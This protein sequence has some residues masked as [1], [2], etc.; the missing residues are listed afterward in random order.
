MITTPEG[1]WPPIYDAEDL[2]RQIRALVQAT[3]FVARFW[4]L[5]SL[6]SVCQGDIV[7]LPSSV[8][9]LDEEGSPVATDDCQHWLVIGN[10]CDFARS[11]ADVAFTQLVPLVNV[12]ALTL[13][14]ID[15][16][17]RYRTSRRFYIPPWPGLE[18]GTHHFADFTRPVP[19]AKQAIGS[20]AR[21]VARMRFP[22]WVLLHSCLIRFLAR[23]D[24]RFDP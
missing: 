3:D 20:A 22:A 24:G 16:Y 9:L 23:D 19:L 8:P 17:R 7:S 5:R 12:G 1:R 6:D 21:V 10:T 2:E 14:Q 11:L 4:D 15:A 13:T 18:Q